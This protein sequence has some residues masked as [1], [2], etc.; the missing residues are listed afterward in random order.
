MYNISDYNLEKELLDEV[1]HNKLRFE[2]TNNEYVSYLQFL[3]EEKT[4]LDSIRDVYFNIHVYMKHYIMNIDELDHNNWTTVDGLVGD[5]YCEYNN[6]KRDD[7]LK[8]DDIFFLYEEG[9]KSFIELKRDI[10]FYD[11]FVGEEVVPGYCGALE[12]DITW[13]ETDLFKEHLHKKINIMLNKS[14][15]YYKNQIDF[16]MKIKGYIEIGGYYDSY[17]GDGDYWEN[18]IGFHGIIDKNILDKY[19]EYCKHYEYLENYY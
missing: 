2:E 4:K 19:E 3:E 9:D 16:H 15:S 18:F 14:E 7:L 6:G 11:I 13:I 8:D 1:W 10:I 12:D 5:F 17:A